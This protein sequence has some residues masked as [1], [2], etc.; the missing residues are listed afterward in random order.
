MRKNRSRKSAPTEVGGYGRG[1]RLAWTLR[2]Q[3]CVGFL[4]TPSW[5]GGASANGRRPLSPFECGTRNGR[6]R[7]NHAIE[8]G[9]VGRIDGHDDLVRCGRAR[10]I[11][12]IAQ[13]A[14]TD[15]IGLRLQ[16]PAGM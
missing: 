11:K 2:L 13:Q 5:E 8:H 4:P 3:E 9:S 16:T 7:I 12:P 10:N 6:L 14:R 15:G 1:M